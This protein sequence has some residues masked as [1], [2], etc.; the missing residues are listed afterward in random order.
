MEF[1][2]TVRFPHPHPSKALPSPAEKRRAGGGG[3]SGTGSSSLSFLDLVLPPSDRKALVQPKKQ[4]MGGGGVLK[5]RK[6]PA[7][8]SH[9]VKGATPAPPPSWSRNLKPALETSGEGG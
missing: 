6:T 1:C 2:L 8:S 7:P 3:G 4:R 5:I 9:P